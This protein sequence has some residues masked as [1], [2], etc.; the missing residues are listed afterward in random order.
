VAPAQ[1]V[2]LDDRP[3]AVEGAAAIGM[4][5]VLFRDNGQAIAAIEALLGSG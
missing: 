2:F 3:A 5:G 1:A 4:T